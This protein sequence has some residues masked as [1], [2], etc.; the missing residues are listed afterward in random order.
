MSKPVLVTMPYLERDFSC[1][2]H[3]PQTSHKTDAELASP[4]NMIW[5]IAVVSR[6]QVDSQKVSHLSVLK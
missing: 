5:K 1:P 6:N 3:N 2:Q 4:H